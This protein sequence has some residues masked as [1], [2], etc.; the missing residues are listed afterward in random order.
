MEGKV[1]LPTTSRFKELRA[2]N[3]YIQRVGFTE[4]AKKTKTYIFYANGDARISHSLLVMKFY[5]KFELGAEIVVPE[6]PDRKRITPA[7]W[8]GIASSLATI[9]IL[10]QTMV[11]NN[12][13]N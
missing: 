12:N 9:A 7:A 10:V 11:N 8:F 2:T 4:N 3:L 6:K 5:P 13:S 1:L